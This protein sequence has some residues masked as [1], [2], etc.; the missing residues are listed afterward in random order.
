M[1]NVMIVDDEPVIRFGLK[2]SIDWKKEGLLV[3]GDYPNGE[4]AWKALQEQPVDILITDIKMPLMDGLE[5]TKRA[6][7]QSPSTK[8][9][10]VSSYADFEF[11]REGLHLGAVD[12]VLKPTLEP[13]EFVLLLRKCC[14]LLEEERTIQEKL[15]F[16]D[17]TEQKTKRDHLEKAIKEVLYEQ[18]DPFSL[19][20]QAEWLQQPLVLASIRLTYMKQPNEPYEFLQKMRLLEEAQVFLYEQE[21]TILCFPVSDMGLFACVPAHS[22]L[23]RTIK[24]LNEKLEEKNAG[25]FTAE[26][27]EVDH[28]GF[29]QNSRIAKQASAGKENDLIAK[30]VHYIHMHYTEELT[31]QKLADHVHLSRNYFSLLFKRFTGQNFIDY[32][33]DLRVRKSKELLSHSSLK[34]YEVAERSGF[35]D[36]KYFSKLFKKVTDLSPVE[37]RL[38]QQEG[39]GQYE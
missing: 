8:V 4:Q 14:C 18:Q 5:L 31:L 1:H 23:D 22:T 10:L 38:K 13:E 36:V 37:Y 16:W 33:I 29:L 19:K 2:A 39:K 32:V 7:S 15:Q 30:A 11:V 12:Y 21:K 17:E 24:Q 35:K 3:V 9:I 28:I 6:L 26:Y 20:E 25:S 27:T 34:V